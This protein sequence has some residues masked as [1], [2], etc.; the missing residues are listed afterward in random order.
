MHAYSNYYTL[1]IACALVSAQSLY[2]YAKVYT[3]LLY[4]YRY[5]QLAANDQFSNLSQDIYKLGE[6]LLSI[7]ANFCLIIERCNPSSIATMFSSRMVLIV[8][9]LIKQIDCNT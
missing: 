5:W 6:S 9:A 4:S 3:V 7:A 2:R 1:T 8:R